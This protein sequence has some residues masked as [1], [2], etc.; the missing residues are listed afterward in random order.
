MKKI[1][2]R[3]VRRLD[4]H[5]AQRADLSAYSSDLVLR[6]VDRYADQ[7]HVALLIRNA[8][9]PYDVVGKARQQLVDLSGRAVVLYDNADHSDSCIQYFTS[10][11][12]YSEIT[13]T[14]KNRTKRRGRYND[15][16]NR[17]R[18]VNAFHSGQPFMSGH[19]YESI[20]SHYIHF[21]NA[22]LLTFFDRFSI[23][24]LDMSY[25]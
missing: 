10:F 7:P 20:L 25:T 23:I 2:N 4:A 22:Y 14:S 24:R 13:P 6:R 11:A 15:P 17:N 16:V 9:T 18:I 8:H 5:A 21:V 19:Q 1:L 3:R 12:A